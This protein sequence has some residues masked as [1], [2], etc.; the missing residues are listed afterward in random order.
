MDIALS[1]DWPA[2]WCYFIIL[3]IGFVVATVQINHLFPGFPQAWTMISNWLLFA[4]FLLLPVVLFWFLDRTNTLHDTSLFGAILVALAYRQIFAGN[5]EK[6]NVPGQASKIWDRVLKWADAQVLETKKRVE[7]NAESFDEKVISFLTQEEK[8]FE[9]VLNLLKLYA[10]DYSKI[11]TDFKALLAKWQPLGDDVMQHKAADYLYH[12]L[13]LAAGDKFT[14]LMYRE[15]ITSWGDYYWYGKELR[16]RVV[17]AIVTGFLLLGA[18]WLFYRLALDPN[19]TFRAD[20]Y[21][22]RLKKANATLEDRS[23]TRR[24]LD[25]LIANNNNNKTNEVARLGSRSET[26]A[27]HDP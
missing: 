25:E 14:D 19:P 13:R 27:G 7:R 24:E 21:V 10:A 20:Y 26:G 3:A 17:Q 16:S 2:L 6:V 22:I 8:A 4:V 9:R 1:P 15:K 11:D 23:R 18:G 5:V 12:Q